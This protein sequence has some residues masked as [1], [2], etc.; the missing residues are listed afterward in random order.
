MPEILSVPTEEVMPPAARPPRVETP[1]PATAA[2]LV[3]PDPAPVTSPRKIAASVPRVD[4]T[5]VSIS[6]RPLEP[7]HTHVVAPAV[8]V[9]ERRRPTVSSPA[10]AER[11]EAQA[12]D[13]TDLPELEPM[14]AD[15]AMGRSTEA[16]PVP[17]NAA[18]TGRTP[19]PSPALPPHEPRRNRPRLNTSDGNVALA[20]LPIHLD[21]TRPVPDV[22]A[23]SVQLESAPGGSGRKPPTEAPLEGTQVALERRDPH[24]PQPEAPVPSNTE[25]HMP[26][27]NQRAV[28]GLA[29]PVMEA[30]LPVEPP[31]IPLKR[32]PVGAPSVAHAEDRP[33]LQ[34]MFVL[35]QPGT[36][37]EFIELFGG[38]DA[39]EQAIRRGLTWIEQHQH[40][41]GHWSLHQFNATCEGHPK[42]AG[43]GS[44]QSDAAA[45]GFALLPF[46][47]AG[48][49]HKSGDHQTAV[50]RGLSWFTEHQKPDGDLFGGPPNNSHMYSHGIAAKGVS[51]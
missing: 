11:Q 1:T 50:A 44:E 19:Q 16:I 35:R 48:H 4:H 29:E 3:R 5:W 43:V 42:C 8:A 41:D 13:A 33:G 38:T 27:D 30:S 25:P 9:I 37:A 7:P 28:V 51:L 18:P 39:S 17:R 26:L 24:L 21:R 34:E 6:I 14:E 22:P 31:M 40:E 10:G 2:Q 20:A 32:Q 36:R 45:T 49:T 12:T 23:E 46:L 47:G 15:L